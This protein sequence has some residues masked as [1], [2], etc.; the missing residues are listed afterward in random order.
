M[1]SRTR[2]QSV[3]Q[4]SKRE[5]SVLVRKYAKALATA[6]KGEQARLKLAGRLHDLAIKVDH[7]RL[8]V[9]IHTVGRR[10]TETKTYKL[11]DPRA[12][13]LFMQ[14]FCNVW[15]PVGVMF[16]V[17]NFGCP[18]T[19]PPAPGFWLGCILIGCSVNV[20]PAP[21]AQRVMCIYLCL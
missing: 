7:A 13:L 17:R 11:T 1:A 21:G 9:D 6:D 10:K 5:A 16:C 4:P 18:A 3:K 2:V 12:A 20:C 19:L 14:R 15:V 8:H